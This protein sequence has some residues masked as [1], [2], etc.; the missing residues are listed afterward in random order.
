MNLHFDPKFDPVYQYSCFK[1]IN[2]IAGLCCDTALEPDFL[3]ISS[4]DALTTTV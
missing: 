2:K 1:H 3:A 4:Q